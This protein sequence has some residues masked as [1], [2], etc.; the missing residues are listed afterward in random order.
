[1]PYNTEAEEAVIGSLLIDGEAIN[2]IGFLEVAHFFSDRTATIYEACKTLREQCESID[3]ITVAQELD[4]QGKLKACGGVAYLSQLISVTPTSMDIEHYAKIV[5]DLAVFRELINIGDKVSELGYAASDV[6]QTLTDADNLI[7]DLRRR[8]GRVSIITPPYRAQ[9]L[10]DRYDKLAHKIDEV[11][12]PTGFFDVDKLLGGGFFP[13]E[14]VILAGDTGL[15]K[16]TLAQCMA[17]YQTYYGNILFCSGEM[18]MEGL[19]DREVAILT[20]RD[21]IEIRAGK[22][23]EEL[24]ND[25][26]GRV[27]PIIGERALYIYN[28]MPLTMSGIEQAMMEMT[29]RHGG[30]KGVVIDY[31]GKVEIDGRDSRYVEIGNITSKFAN[32]AKEYQVPVLLLVQL[33]RET[34]KQPEKRPQLYSLYESGRIE[35]DADV[36]LFLYRVDKY[37]SPEEWPQ[38]KSRDDGMIYGDTYPENVAELIIAKQRQ[39]GGKNRMVK[40]LWHREQRQYVNMATDTTPIIYD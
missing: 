37:I 26:I 15:G 38:K 39:G 20:K 14:L 1:M 9:L 17:A 27:L 36:V 35:H 34:M 3:Q 40:I 10:L 32:L 2:Q 8:H 11:S 33:N 13:G 4:R 28:Q 6:A 19:S 24:F 7:T 18:T 29:V 22:Y 31:L 5:R 21:V 23:D 12:L 25:I 16:S 30:L